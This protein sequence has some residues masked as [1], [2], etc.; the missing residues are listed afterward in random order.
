MGNKAAIVK[1]ASAKNIKIITIKIS[2]ADPKLNEIN[3]ADIPS[4]IRKF[5]KVIISAE[6]V[7]KNGA[8]IAESGALMIALA[9]RKYNVPVI[10]ICR[11]FSLT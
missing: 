10:A 9:A 11:G 4:K 2:G 1:T 3:L 6:S 7:L 8:I 5:Q